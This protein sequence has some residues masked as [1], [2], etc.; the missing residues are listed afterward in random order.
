MTNGPVNPRN[1]DFFAKDGI[2]VAQMLTA[3]PTVMIHE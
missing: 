2:V 3:I 1:P